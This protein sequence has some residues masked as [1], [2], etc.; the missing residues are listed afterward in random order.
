MLELWKA[1]QEGL[2]HYW[3]SYCWCYTRCR[4][5]A[6]N[7]WSPSVGMAAAPHLPWYPAL[8]FCLLGSTSCDCLQHK[9][10]LCSRLMQAGTFLL[11]V[12]WGRDHPCWLSCF[13][14][15]IPS[16]FQF[17]IIFDLCFWF[18]AT[19]NFFLRLLFLFW[20]S[21]FLHYFILFLSV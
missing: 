13:Q 17:K 14:L 16:I 20:I 6:G 19:C 9:Q 8:G 7:R 2:K 4:C 18:P 10:L 21:F 11:K 3:N 12:Q 5:W 1:G 15:S